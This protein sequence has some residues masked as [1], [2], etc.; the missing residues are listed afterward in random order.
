MDE[1]PGWRLIADIRR[2]RRPE[3]AKMR[4]GTLSAILGFLLFLAVFLAFCTCWEMRAK[5][6]P[7][8]AG[9]E[10]CSGPE[11]LASAISAENASSSELNLLQSAARQAGLP[12][13]HKLGYKYMAA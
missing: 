5:Q 9:D 10:E 3:Y 1:T 7:G 11:L 2:V 13:P 4:L 6:R 12:D 8:L